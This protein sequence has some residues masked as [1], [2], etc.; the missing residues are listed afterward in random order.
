MAPKNVVMDGTDNMKS[1]GMPAAWQ[2][3]AGALL[4]VGH[5]HSVGGVVGAQ[6]PSHHRMQFL[7]GTLNGRRGRSDEFWSHYR[8]LCH[9]QRNQTAF[10]VAT[11]E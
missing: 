2:D 8:L 6:G 3:L 11:T 5:R 9:R 4:G 1:Q 10:L 7:K